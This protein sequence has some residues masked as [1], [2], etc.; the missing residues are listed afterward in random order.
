M[1]GNLKVDFRLAAPRHAMKQKLIEFPGRG[2]VRGV[3]NLLDGFSL[4]F[5]RLESV[6]GFDL[7]K[8]LRQLARDGPL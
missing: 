1:I 4:R 6:G 7:F 5:R 3:I 2:G 8:F